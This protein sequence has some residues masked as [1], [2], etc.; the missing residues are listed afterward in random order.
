MSIN[1]VPT[2][3]F[4]E[5][6]MHIPVRD[7]SSVL[8]VNKEW[9]REYRYIVKQN[10]NIIFEAILY[11]DCNY[12]NISNITSHQYIG[13]KSSYFRWDT[14]IRNKVVNLCRT[15]DI[16]LETKLRNTLQLLRDEEKKLLTEKWSEERRNKQ[17]VNFDKQIKIR[18]LFGYPKYLLL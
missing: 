5:I 4:A 3:V 8:R 14:F 16:N 6:L 11:S 12:W 10:F 17:T 2:E 1:K 15:F 7:A 18:R 13:W 9:Y